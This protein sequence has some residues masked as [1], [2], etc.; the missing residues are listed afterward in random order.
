[1][2]RCVWVYFSLTFILI[3]RPNIGCEGFLRSPIIHFGAVANCEFYDIRECAFKRFVRNRC[4]KEPCIKFQNNGS[5]VL[6][7]MR[8]QI[9]GS[10]LKEGLQNP[11]ESHHGG[12]G[13]LWEPR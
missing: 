5:R 9:S 4:Q 10:W 6:P 2:L 12:C 13:F 1:M 11:K 8:V 7:C 3:N